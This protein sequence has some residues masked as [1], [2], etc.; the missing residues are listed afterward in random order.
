MDRTAELK[1]QA[2]ELVKAGR[3]HTLLQLPGWWWV[4]SAQSFLD[5]L[6]NVPDTLSLAKQIHC[7]VLALRGDQEDRTRYPAEEFQAA[8]D[9]PCD[10][11]V[12]ENCD[13]FYNQRETEVA[14]RVAGWLQKTLGL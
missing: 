6:E 8:C 1:S 12:I 13:H 14:A 11:A 9:G 4:I 7:P 10:V 5:R 3:G 2:Q